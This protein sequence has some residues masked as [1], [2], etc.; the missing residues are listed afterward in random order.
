MYQSQGGWFNIKMP[1]YEYRKSHCGD[2]TILRP[3]YL[4]N[5][6][7]CTG[8]TTSL[9]WIRAQISQQYM[10]QRARIWLLHDTITFKV[11]AVISSSYLIKWILFNFIYIDCNTALSILRAQ[12]WRAIWIRPMLNIFRGFTHSKRFIAYAWMGNG[13]FV[14]I[15]IGRLL[16]IIKK[17]MFNVN[18]SV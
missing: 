5:G 8:K 13:C 15:L 14:I 10:K 2:K 7:S 16:L 17:L 11:F 3:S 6:I 1:S 9:Y 12:L 18:R 4:H